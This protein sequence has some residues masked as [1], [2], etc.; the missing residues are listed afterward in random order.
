MSRRSRKDEAFSV[1]RL[2]LS[3]KDQVSVR[4][5]QACEH[6]KCYIYLCAFIVCRFRLRFAGRKHKTASRGPTLAQLHSLLAQLPP[7]VT[8][9]ESEAV[10]RHIATAVVRDDVR[11]SIACLS[12]NVRFFSSC[13]NGLSTPS[14]PFPRRC[15]GRRIVD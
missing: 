3:S 14:W 13:R 9:P 1:P 15:N 6:E 10:E 11:D 4:L 12:T 5:L 8:S 7:L 2:L